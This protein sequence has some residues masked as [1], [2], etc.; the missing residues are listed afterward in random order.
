MKKLYFLKLVFGL[1]LVAA[2]NIEAQELILGGDMETADD[3]TIIDLAAGN[4][5]TETFGYTDDYPTDGEGGCLSMAGMGN[6]SNAAVCQEITVTRGVTYKISMVVRTSLDFAPQSN[7]VEIVV[8][9][10]MPV[11][12]GDITAYPN[13]FAL[14]SW[15]CAAV[16]SVD[17]NFA[18]NNCDA[19]SALND[20]INIEGEGDTTVVLVLKTGG[21]NEYNVL[22]DNVSVMEQEGVSVKNNTTNHGVNVFPTPV[23]NELNVNM[24][25]AIQNIEIVNVLGQSVYSAKNINV[26]SLK[27]DVSD[28]AA[29]IYLG[30]VYDSDGKKSMFKTI[31]K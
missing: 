3:W 16:L 28:L 13:V 22:L 12:D 21:N 6:W 8:V 10:T 15:D 31:K 4:G 27:I 23:Q 17:G 14:N 29:G 18:D 9:P 2:F 24:N 19:K 5:H 20:I 30:T 11:D 7:W 26:H 25:K 1:M